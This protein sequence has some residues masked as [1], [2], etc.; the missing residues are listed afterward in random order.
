MTTDKSKRQGNRGSTKGTQQYCSIISIRVRRTIVRVV[1]SSIC[2]YSE[3]AGLSAGC[4]DLPPTFAGEPTTSLNATTTGT[5]KNEPRTTSPNSRRD[6]V[7]A[8]QRALP[9]LTNLLCS[10]RGALRRRRV[11]MIFSERFSF[12]CQVQQACL[13]CKSD[14]STAAVVCQGSTNQLNNVAIG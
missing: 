4:M 6:I 2:A 3:R 1:H 13:S 9:S 10:A 12:C 5:A 11:S 14:I 8:Y 7:V